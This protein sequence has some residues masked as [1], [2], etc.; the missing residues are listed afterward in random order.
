MSLNFLKFIYTLRSASPKKKFW[1]RHRK[2]SFVEIWSTQNN[3]TDCAHD[4]SKFYLT[5]WD[6]TY[7]THFCVAS[8]SSSFFVFFDPDQRTEGKSPKFSYD[9]VVPALIGVFFN[10]A[11]LRFFSSVFRRSFLP[12][13][14]SCVTW[15][16]THTVFFFFW[17]P[18]MSNPIHWCHR[19]SVLVIHLTG[20][21]RYKA[22][23]RHTPQFFL[24]FEILYVFYIFTL[25]NFLKFF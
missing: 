2:I 13:C 23:H 10:T 19:L 6:I 14:G 16:W 11:H 22:K 17:D 8:S 15:K 20:R 4:V 25:Q 1:I 12:F 9:W 24:F 3:Y 5:L 18:H 7:T 21:P